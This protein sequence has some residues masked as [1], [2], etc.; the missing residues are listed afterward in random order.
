M[1]GHS[2]GGED[3]AFSVTVIKEAIL[4]NRNSEYRK[5]DKS[6]HHEERHNAQ[7]FSFIKDYFFKL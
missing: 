3:K 6:S 7:A 1:L 4:I 2:M 5:I